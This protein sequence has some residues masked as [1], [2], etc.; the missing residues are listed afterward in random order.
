M[1]TDKMAKEILKNIRKAV[2]QALAG[3]KKQPKK[4]AKK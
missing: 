2:K 3:K 4:L 1:G